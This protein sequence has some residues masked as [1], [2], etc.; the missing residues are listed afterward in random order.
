MPTHIVSGLIAHATAHLST[1]DESGHTA[2]F[3][4]VIQ[5]C[6]SDD[7]IQMSPGRTMNGDMQLTQFVL[8]LS[9]AL[10]ARPYQR[11]PEWVM[12]M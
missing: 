12:K 6:D 3:T 8:L 1:Y 11:L 5:I 7:V 2:A 10:L 9:E 4:N